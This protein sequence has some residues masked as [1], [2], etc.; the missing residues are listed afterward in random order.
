M[1]IQLGGLT[2]HLNHQ[3]MIRRK[4]TA[5]GTAMATVRFAW[6]MVV[7][8]SEAGGRFCEGEWYVNLDCVE[9][10]MTDADYEPWRWCLN[11]L[12]SGKR[13]LRL[14]LRAYVD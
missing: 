1:Y 4:N 7:V 12:E 13:L 8:R 14:M 10:G 3:I 9:S 5:I 6:S 11:K 2:V